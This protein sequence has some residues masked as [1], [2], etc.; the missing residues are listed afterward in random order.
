MPINDHWDHL[1]RSRKLARDR[2]KEPSTTVHDLVCPGAE[3]VVAHCGIIIAN[4]RDAS[5]GNQRHPFARGW[6]DLTYIGDT[7]V[8]ARKHSSIIKQTI[9]QRLCSMVIPLC[10]RC[11]WCKSG[12]L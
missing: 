9:W 2:E 3:N 6:P 5:L 12:D 4:I 8:F 11:R 7:A 10:K 1:R